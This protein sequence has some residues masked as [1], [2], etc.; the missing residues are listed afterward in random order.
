MDTTER[1]PE[2][3]SF[4]VDPIPGAITM[5]LRECRVQELVMLG[6]HKQRQV[7]TVRAFITDNPRVSY[8]LSDA[9]KESS[10]V[11]V[12]L[13]DNHLTI[14]NHHGRN[15]A[16]FL[17]LVRGPSGML[18]YIGV[19]VS[20]TRPELA[21]SY[22]RAEINRLLDRF[23]AGSTHP[24]PLSIQRLELL[25]PKDGETIAYELMIPFEGFT[26]IGQTGG[27][28]PVGLFAG[29]HAIFR[30]AVNNPSPYYRLLLAYRAFEGIANLRQRISK[31]R[32]HYK[33]DERMPKETRLDK[34]EM[35]RLR[36][37]PEVRKLERVG[38]LFSYFGYLRDG[39]AHF[40]LKPDSSGEGHI[41]LS[42][43]MINTYATVGALL[44]RYVRTESRSLEQYYQ[45]YV[46]PHLDLGS[47]IL[48]LLQYREHFI[49]VAP[50]EESEMYEEEI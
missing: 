12:E 38:Q 45:K 50:D 31:A 6:F 18:S 34:T 44:L 8:R 7:F 47:L 9:V 42:S 16:V 41:Y 15:K 10:S 33:I 19:Q 29:H 17:D 35:G 43:V 27:F 22:S 13:L 30:E 28:W 39:I 5:V 4:L 46:R 3:L 1:N 14:F 37:S 23:T 48:P 26:Q 36:L 21:L 40:L 11:G 24:H 20:A 25:S 32:E 49:V 2:A